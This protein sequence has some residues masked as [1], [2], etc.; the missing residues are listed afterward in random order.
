MEVDAIIPVW[1]SD[2]GVYLIQA[3]QSRL[4]D[5][6]V[7]ALR[8]SAVIVIRLFFHRQAPRILLPGLAENLKA[9][10]DIGK[11]QAAVHGLDK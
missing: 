5:V 4:L 3:R 8:P 6:A 7:N 10:S 2:R 1:P 11:G 9:R